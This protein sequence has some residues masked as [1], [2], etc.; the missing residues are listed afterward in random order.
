MFNDRDFDTI[1]SEMMSNFGTDVRTDEGSL[2]YNA[3]AKIAEKLEEVYGDI[4]ELYANILPDTQDDWHL[5]EYAR[6]KG[7]IYKYATAP[8]VKGV[9]EQEIEIGERFTCND[10]TYSVSKKLSNYAYEMICETEGVAANTTFGSLSP[11]DYVDDYQRG[12]ITEIITPGT[13]DEDIEKFRQ[14]VLDSY[15]NIAFA[16]N[17]AAYRA[18][19][20]SLDG[21]G[22]SKPF[23]READSDFI[24]VYVISSGYAAPSDELI[25]KIQTEVDPEQNHG[26]GLGL[27]PI[28][29]SVQII[30]VEEVT[31]KVQ[32]NITYDTGYSADNTKTL[33]EDAISEY[34]HGLCEIWESRE[35]ENI[36]VR[37]S[38]IES[39]ILQIN[40][41]VDIVDTM[42]NGETKNA[43]ITYTAIP[44][45]GGVDIV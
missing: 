16:G 19:V 41:I 11:V 21:V 24:K 23:R 29:H 44:V 26:D 43:T 6:G 37:I 35:K 39:R 12:E 40:G 13:D 20:N 3:C 18:F 38:Q 15:T 5:I 33:I 14:K 34:L 30:P 4:D 31:I 8:V 17:R 42:I 7:I 36:I 2:A 10:Y 9:F 45:F 25:N 22:G 28:D 27:A 32:T 1:M